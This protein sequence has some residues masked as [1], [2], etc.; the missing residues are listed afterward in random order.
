MFIE[1]LVGL[2]STHISKH[3]KLSSLFAILAIS[4]YVLALLDKK[5]NFFKNHISY[6]QGLISGT[7][8]SVI[9]ALLSP[10]SQW[11]IFNYITPN[12]FNNAIEYSLTSGQFSSYEEAKAKFNLNNYM[13]ISFLWAIFIGIL[14][15]LILMIFIKSKS[16]THAK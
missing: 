5:K 8:L 12:F 14:T 15:T 2:H 11:I 9:I 7:I 10:L 3:E 4:I 6:K 1:K 16:S 13:L